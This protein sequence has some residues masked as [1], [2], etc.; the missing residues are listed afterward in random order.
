MGYLR[1][2]LEPAEREAVEEQLL[3]D[4]QLRVELELIHQG[5]EPLRADRGTFA[6]PPGLAE[7]TCEFVAIKAAVQVAPAVVMPP[8][9]RWTMADMVVA[10]GGCARWVTRVASALSRLQTEG[11]A[12]RPGRV[13]LL[14][15]PVDLVVGAIGL[16]GAFLEI[17]PLRLHRAEAAH[18]ELMAQAAAAL[19]GYRSAT[20]P[21]ATPQ[22]GMLV[23]A[24]NLADFTDRALHETGCSFCTR[25]HFGRP[26]PGEDRAYIRLAY[27]GIPS[28]RITEGLGKL[29]D[30]IGNPA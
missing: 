18:V 12:Q 19:H 25:D 23:G 5:L 9:S 16:D 13:L 28:D 20:R 7:R 24:R 27:S 1:D 6:P 29:R 22:R 8:R 14:V 26:Q 17:A 21:E 30:G 4:P 15:G 3:N 2:A 10:A 11:A